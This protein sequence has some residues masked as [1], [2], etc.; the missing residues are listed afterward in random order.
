MEVL[1][2][3][4]GDPRLLVVVALFV[5]F[6]I[7]GARV[8]MRV[9]RGQVGRAVRS[10]IE[11]LRAAEVAS[12]G[13]DGYAIPLPKQALQHQPGP[14]TLDP[15]MIA[16]GFLAEIEKGLRLAVGAE[17]LVEVKWIYISSGRPGV[18]PTRQ[19]VAVFTAKGSSSHGNRA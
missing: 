1:F 13:Q 4:L 15:R 18:G 14:S 6:V 17:Y 3:K 8:A 10:I 16:A 5:A 9:D 11:S 19:E 2:L 12:P 7:G